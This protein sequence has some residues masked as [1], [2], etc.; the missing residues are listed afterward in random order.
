MDCMN[1]VLFLYNPSFQRK[2]NKNLGGDLVALIPI[3]GTVTNLSQMSTTTLA[4][5]CFKCQV[6]AFLCPQILNALLL[7]PAASPTTW[8]QVCQHLGLPLTE[9]VTMH[10]DA[11][12]TCLIVTVHLW[13]Q[14]NLC[15]KQTLLDMLNY[16]TI[17]MFHGRWQQITKVPV[18]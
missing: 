9:T 16:I 17:S 12:I 4:V 11:L 15:T 3:K 18:I 14:C 7:T 1:E 13:H 6:V 2:K 8:S 10:P 5:T